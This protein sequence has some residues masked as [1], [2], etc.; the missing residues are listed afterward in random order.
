M[1]VFLFFAQIPQEEPDVCSALFFPKI[2]DD[3][4]MFVFLS[5]AKNQQNPTRCL[6]CSFLSKIGK[7]Q[8]HVCVSLLKTSHPGPMSV[9]LFS[10]SKSRSIRSPASLQIPA[11]RDDGRALK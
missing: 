6:W 7:Y 2:K 4:D 1:S 8:E 3:K 5:S 11:S 10:A 9:A